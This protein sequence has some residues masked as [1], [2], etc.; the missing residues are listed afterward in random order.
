M[1]DVLAVV[2]TYMSDPKDLEVTAD[3]LRSLRR[4]APDLDVLIV[5]D[6]S[7]R[8]DLVKSLESFDERC[9]LVAKPE[10][11]GFATTVNVGLRR[12]LAETRDVVLVNADVEFM[13]DGWL[14]RMSEQ[15]GVDGKPASVVGAL[16]LYPNDLI[17]H[18]GIFFSLLHKCFEHRF[19][20]APHNLPEAHVAAQCPVTG[21]LQ[22]IR[23]EALA[24][25]GLYDDEFQLAWEDVDYCIR[26]FL[27]RHDVI[28]QPTVR[29][30]HHESLFRGRPNPKIAD[31]Q[32]RSWIYFMQKWSHQNFMHFVPD[33][34]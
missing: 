19:K 6:G 21:A 30:Y 2:P 22:F 8:S 7:P 33:F 29:A 20:Y 5:D 24:D 16:L 14:E 15:V 13:D 23:H 31:M 10:N 11:E 18:G 17:Q 12:A 26:C 34:V 1:R 28:Y 32:A 4:T 25:V 3:M 9:E 27:A